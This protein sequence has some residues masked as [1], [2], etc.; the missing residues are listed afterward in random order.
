MGVNEKDV[1]EAVPDS[2]ND[3]NY[4]ATVVDNNDQ[5]K[6]HLGN[7]QIQLIAIGGSIGTATFVS[8]TSGL[9]KG[10]PGSLFLAYTIYSCMMGLVNNCMA[11]MAVFMP[12]SG[13]FIRMAGKWVDESFGFW[14]GWNFFLYEVLLIPFEI[15]AL[16]LVLTFWRDD[17]PVEAVVAACIV[18]YLCVAPG[19]G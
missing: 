11:E 2:E 15:T 18:I 19:S 10:G 12:V 14:A 8:I 9:T 7:R 3:K 16:N 5:L 1:A 4:V 6:R 17:I 13:A